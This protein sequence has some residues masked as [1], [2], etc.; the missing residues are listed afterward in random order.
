MG[1]DLSAG[2][3]TFALVVGNNAAP[4]GTG[5]K[6]LK[7]S[8]D[9][10]IRYYN[11]FGMFASDVQLLTVPDSRTQERYPTASSVAKVPSIDN[12]TAA[13]Q[14]LGRAI[15]KAKADGD[16][17]VLYIAF[18][19]HGAY[20]ENGN[21][22]LALI[23]GRLTADKIY[24]ALTTLDADYAHL[25]ID[26]CYAEGVVGSRGLFDDEAEVE[27]VRLSEAGHRKLTGAPSVSELPGLGIVMASSEYQ[28][29]HEWSRIESG[30]FTHEVLS[31]LAGPA[32]I[33][34]D[35]KIEYSELAAF[36]S[37]ANRNVK[38]ARG[39]IRLI[40]SPPARLESVPLVDFRAFRR[41]AFLTGSLSQ[42]G[43][44]HIE[45][46]NG[47]RY[48]DAHLGPN[49]AQYIVLPIGEGELA[50]LESGERE[51][52][53]QLGIDRVI[54]M[55]T[56]D[57]SAPQYRHRGPIE[58][59]FSTGLFSA[60]YSPEYYQGFVDS[61]SFKS[62]A[63][64]VTAFSIEKPLDDSPRDPRKVAALA[65]F[66]LAGA[67]AIAATALGTL[68]LVEYQKFSNTALEEESLGIE[69][70]YTRYTA[71]FWPVASL[72]PIGIVL[73]MFF[74][75]KSDRRSDKTSLLHW[76]WSPGRVVLNVR[77]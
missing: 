77:F 31:G 49:S 37:A 52:V 72:V 13:V 25:F 33:N 45:L 11:F 60:K 69:R 50:Y 68:A 18:S 42:L 22:Y 2:T 63:F 59:A 44:F 20:D 35:G 70:R 48:L 39:R 15:D 38:D 5:L 43:R 8:D 23:S 51:A 75:H 58:A 26:A 24:S 17:V 27:H 9:D 40:A 56:L 16:K 36:V 67:A 46:S 7:Y 73:G 64:N 34:K 55:S 1:A 57:F 12:F 29:T 41:G 19:G 66:S 6:T 76:D 28:R 74:W 32:D 65:S 53:L 47:E 14:T 54:P 3:T 62:V 61:T 4:R 71:L 21:A 10:A 30:V